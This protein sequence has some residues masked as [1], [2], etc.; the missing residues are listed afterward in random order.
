MSDEHGFRNDGPY[1]AGGREPYQGNDDM[2]KQNEDV[3]HTPNPTRTS[4][5]GGIQPDF[6]TRHTQPAKR[7]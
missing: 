7:N 3:A 4:Q 2:D 6:L 5:I 1:A